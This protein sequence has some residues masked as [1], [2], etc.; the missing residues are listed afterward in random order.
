VNA[1]EFF[2]HTGWAFLDPDGDEW[3]TSSPESNPYERPPDAAL[4]QNLDGSWTLRWKEKTVTILPDAEG[5]PDGVRKIAALA[6]FHGVQYP[7]SF[8]HRKERGELADRLANIPR[9]PVFRYDEDCGRDEYADFND[10]DRNELRNLAHEAKRKAI[11]ARLSGQ[12]AKCHQNQT[13]AKAI[14]DGLDSVSSVLSELKRI[15]KYNS[16]DR[17]AV[18]KSIARGIDLIG[19]YIPEAAEH[20]KMS[21]DCGETCI[22]MT[23]DQVQEKNIR[24]RNYDAPVPEDIGWHIEGDFL[25]YL[26]ALGWNLRWLIDTMVH[27]GRMGVPKWAPPEWVSY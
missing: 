25:A 1:D 24:A 11:S 23:S 8:L 19:A 13:L 16:Q 5:V 22:Y 12:I 27:Y 14:T 4:V 9:V 17:H 21:I 2:A 18:Q 10:M 3:E 6:G 15:D 26:P 7:C 20:L